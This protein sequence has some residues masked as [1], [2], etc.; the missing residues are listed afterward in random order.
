MIDNLD[1]QTQQLPLEQKRGRGRP[2]TGQALSNAERQRA[3]RERQKAQRNE[4]Q[5]SQKVTYDEVVAIAQELGERCKAAEE[6][7][8]KALERIEELEAESKKRARTIV[9]QARMIQAADEKLAQRNEKPAD[10][11]DQLNGVWIV[12]SKRPGSRIWKPCGNPETNLKD[13][14]QAVDYMQFKSGSGQ[15]EE[16]RAI[17]ADGLFYWPLWAK[18][19]KAAK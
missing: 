10:Q 5:D 12:E 8:A 16:W 3:Y 4:K 19:T 18:K 17:R 14:R 7:L 11:N 15:G 1:K 9:E 6:K 13:A 2:A